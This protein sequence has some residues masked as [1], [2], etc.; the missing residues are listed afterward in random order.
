MCAFQNITAVNFPEGIGFF[1]GKIL[2][3]DLSLKSSISQGSVKMFKLCK[4]LS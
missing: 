1:N 2:Q 3:P 4:S